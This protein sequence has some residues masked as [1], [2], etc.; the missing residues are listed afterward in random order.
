LLGSWPTSCEWSDRMALKSGRSARGRWG[1]LLAGMWGLP[2]HHVAAADGGEQPAASGCLGP[3][4]AGVD[5]GAAAN[6]QDH[7]HPPVSPPRRGPCDAAPTLTRWVP[8]HSA[9]GKPSTSAWGRT[10]TRRPRSPVGITSPTTDTQAR[11]QGCHGIREYPARSGAARLVREDTHGRW[12]WAMSSGARAR[13][14]RGG[15]AW[16]AGPRYPDRI[17]RVQAG[18]AAAG[19]AGRV[20]ARRVSGVAS[21]RPAMSTS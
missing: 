8:E 14:R 10:S 21:G 15:P 9:D 13:S 20:A 5:G 12:P 11:A 18:C 7:E 19:P 16:Q 4:R 2:E 17:A 3:G 1:G 6:A